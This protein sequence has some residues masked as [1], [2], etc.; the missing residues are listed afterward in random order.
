MTP[1]RLEI[2]LNCDTLQLL[3][4]TERKGMV[5]SNKKLEFSLL[6]NMKIPLR[7]VRLTLRLLST[8]D[9][10]VRW[11]SSMAWYFRFTYLKSKLI[12]L[13]VNDLG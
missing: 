10:R 5:S 6:K 11:R 12:N 2:A 4:Y 8:S 1:L 7:M 9:L 3:I 13:L